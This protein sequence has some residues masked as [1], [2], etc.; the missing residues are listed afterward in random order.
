MLTRHLLLAAITPAGISIL[1]SHFPPGPERGRAFALLGAGQPIGYIIGLILGGIL[2]DS[3]A[4]W[5][6]IFWLEAGLAA[7]LCVMGW[8]VLPKDDTSK[9][10]T[11]GLDWI[12][13]VL[14]TA[15]LAL[16]VYD[17]A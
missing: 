9:R 17:L 6:T 16:L 10:Y 12:G 13:A 15:G 3:S 4:S 5:R 14:S 2:S 8:F 7:F 1:S 11:R